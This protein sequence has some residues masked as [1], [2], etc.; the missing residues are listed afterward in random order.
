MSPLSER[1]SNLWLRQ[2]PTPFVPR[3]EAEPRTECMV[4][5]LTK[6]LKVS[7]TMLWPG[8]YVFQLLEPEEGRHLVNI[9]N[10]D[11]TRL[12]ATRVAVSDD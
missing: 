6:P 2:P 7:G 5:T 11:Q 10:E 9:F 4:V 8:R 12:V 1:L 3:A